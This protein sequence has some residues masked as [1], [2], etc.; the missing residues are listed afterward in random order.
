[1]LTI[2]GTRDPY[3]ISQWPTIQQDVKTYAASLSSSDGLSIRF[4]SGGLPGLPRIHVTEVNGDCDDSNNENC[5]RC[6]TLAAEF[7]LQ[8]LV[9]LDTDL[10]RSLFSIKL[11]ATG[12]E[13]LQPEFITWGDS[14]AVSV[15]EAYSD[16]DNSLKPLGSKVFGQKLGDLARVLRSKNAGVNEV[17]FDLIFDEQSDLF[18]I[19]YRSDIITKLRKPAVG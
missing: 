19:L 11:H 5:W 13:D 8:H 14:P 18:I 17:T 12:V 10:L 6:D 9:D 1:M 3:F 7:T 15:D 4:I 2:C 16:W